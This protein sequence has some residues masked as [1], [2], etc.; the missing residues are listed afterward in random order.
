MKLFRF[1]F[2]LGFQSISTFAACRGSSPER[3]SCQ[4]RQ[5]R[6]K[7]ECNFSASVFCN[8]FSVYFPYLL[9]LDEVTT[10][11]DLCELCHHQYP[12][13]SQNPLARQQIET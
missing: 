6:R 1:L 11:A 8:F 12:L 3:T 9:F 10:L 7:D 5:R 4:L 2:A 13:D